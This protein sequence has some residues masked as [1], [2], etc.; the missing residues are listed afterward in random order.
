MSQFLRKG[1]EIKKQEKLSDSQIMKERTKVYGPVKDQSEYQSSWG[2]LRAPGF[3]PLLGSF[4]ILRKK[5]ESVLVQ[6]ENLG[7]LATDP[8][9]SDQNVRMLSLTGGELILWGGSCH[10]FALPLDVCILEPVRTSNPRS[11]HPSPL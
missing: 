11:Q 10:L 2:P 7:L 3:S 4:R 6:V 1:R 5:I 9:K 8:I